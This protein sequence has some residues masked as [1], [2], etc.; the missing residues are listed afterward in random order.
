MSFHFFNKKSANKKKEP[1]ISHRVNQ[2]KKNASHQRPNRNKIDQSP[3]KPQDLQGK[4][5]KPPLKNRA[6]ESAGQPIDSTTRDFMEARFGFD[7]SRVRVHT[8][9]D[10]R[11]SAKQAGALAYTAGQDVVFGA[12]QYDPGTD[13]G[14]NLL[15]HELTHVV[16][17]ARGGA[18]S[19]PEQ[20][21]D[22]AAA[23]VMQA[24]EVSPASIG[25][26]SLP[27]QTKP[28]DPQA[29]PEKETLISKPA[30]G[31]W[32]TTVDRFGHNQSG[33]TDRHRNRIK[34]LA[35]EI[36]ARVSAEG[37][38]ATI[39]ISGHTDTSGDEEYNKNLGMRRA[40]AAKAE[41]EAALKKKKVSADRIVGITAE[42]AGEKDLAVK[43]ADKV[44]E[45]LNRRVVITTKVEGPPASVPPPES[46]PSPDAEPEKRKTPID[47]NLP[48]DFKLP[49]ESLWERMERQRKAIED[50]DR[51][52]RLEPKSATDILVD[53]VTK[54]LEPIIKKLPEGLRDKAREGIRKG[55][56]A[57]TEKACEAAIDAS[58]VSGE[59]AEAMKA[60]CKAALKSK[61]GS[62]R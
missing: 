49:E 50:Y 35:D 24:E 28:G 11:E 17:Q 32:M 20:R 36:A 25:G 16:Q 6:T 29:K 54:L 5:A 43:T 33:L 26:T 14:R 55:I 4:A 19:Q 61:T 39:T 62:K 10:A 57:G 21:A 53:G 31:S 2:R 12:R 58:G 30:P 56:E 59:Q 47:F 37:A 44:K 38:R 9:E 40:N 1:L 34:A 46:I 23:S 18:S 27:V 13:A 45:P 60:A 52:H 51:T 7:F 8:G 41:L 48:P 42:S 22:A 3:E 15:A